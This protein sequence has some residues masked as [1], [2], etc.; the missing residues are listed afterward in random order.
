M[1][2]LMQ[3]G[4]HQTLSL[5]PSRLCP[6]RPHLPHRS[7][8]PGELQPVV[9]APRSPRHVAPPA[10]HR[11]ATCPKKGRWGAASNRAAGSAGARGPKLGG[12]GQCQMLLLW[13]IWRREPGAL[14]RSQVLAH[15]FVGSA[16]P[17]GLA[18]GCAADTDPALPG[19]FW[20]RWSKPSLPKPDGTRLQLGSRGGSVPGGQSPAPPL[21]G[22]QTARLHCAP[23]AR[24]LH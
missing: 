15:A 5:L 10:W 4:A 23:R 21:S 3:L 2:P 16:R 20:L 12:G 18:R 19:F 22:V 14:S 6:C 11:H 8:V 13:H 17:V 9:S 1:G 7:H 24:C